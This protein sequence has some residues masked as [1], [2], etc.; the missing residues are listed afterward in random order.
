[1]DNQPNKDY[2]INSLVNQNSRL[3]VQIAERD[4]II[5]EQ[6]QELERLNHKEENNG[7]HKQETINNK[8]TK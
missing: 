6:Q 5:A 7:G 1:M 3:S 8:E 4:A 2:M